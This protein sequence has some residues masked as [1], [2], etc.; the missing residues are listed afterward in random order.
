MVAIGIAVA[1]P[2]VKLLFVYILCGIVTTFIS[3]GIIVL[4]FSLSIV[5]TDSVSVIIARLKPSVVSVTITVCISLL[6]GFGYTVVRIS[7]NALDNL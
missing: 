3:E 4:V 7:F 5:K 2:L 6:L 1:I